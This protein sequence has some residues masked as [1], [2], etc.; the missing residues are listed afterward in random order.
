MLAPVAHL[1]EPMAGICQLHLDIDG[2]DDPD[3][4]LAARAGNLLV[5]PGAPAAPP[6]AVGHAPPA[7]WCDALLL[8]GGPIAMSG[9]EELLAAVV[10]A[11]SKALL[12]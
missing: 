10:G 6:E 11:M 4:Y 2:T 12:A 1:S 9:D 8:R 3:V 5:L 7:T